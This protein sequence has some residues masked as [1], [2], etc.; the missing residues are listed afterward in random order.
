MCKKNFIT[1]FYDPAH[2]PKNLLVK[3]EEKVDADEK[4]PHILHSEVRK[5][6]KEIRDKRLQKMTM[7]KSGCT[8][9][10]GKTWSQTNDTSDQHKC[11]RRKAQG[12]H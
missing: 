8:E 1:E 5:A 12:F 9:I 10:V 2:R 3:H 7:N 11:N 6:I 4:G